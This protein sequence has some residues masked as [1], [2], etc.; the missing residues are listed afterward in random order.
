MTRFNYL[1]FSDIRKRFDKD[2][3]IG[4]I[5]G[6]EK[7][8][9]FI[10]QNR[11]IVSYSDRATNI[12]TVD[13]HFKE[14]NN[15]TIEFFYWSPEALD[16]QCKQVHTIKR[17]LEAFPQYRDFWDA[18]KGMDFTTIRLVHERLL[19]TVLY[20][21]WDNTWY[22][23]DKALSDWYSEFDSWFFKDY[24]DT[25]AYH[26]WKSGIKYVTESIGN[27]V[28]EDSNGIADGLVVFHKRYLIGEMKPILA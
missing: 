15:S 14:Y 3:S 17:W 19:R 5:M 18:E 11:F 20:T 6:I 27:F 13:E 12:T 28:K 9:C 21:T 4:I 25:N 8:R 2:K 23:S 10:H 24:Q 26:I 7:P 16:I 1:H 22:Q